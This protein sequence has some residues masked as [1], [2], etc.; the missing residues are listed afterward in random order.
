MPTVEFTR[1]LARHVACPTET[2]RG[3]TVG[4]ALD[5]YFERHPDVRAYVLDEQGRVR[6]HVTI[7]VDGRQLRDRGRLDEPVG[8]GSVVSVMQALSGG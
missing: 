1:N 4:A 7:F 3:E 5:D 6:H 8:E 2:A